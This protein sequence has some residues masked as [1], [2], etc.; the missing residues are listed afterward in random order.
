MSPCLLNSERRASIFTPPISPLCQLQFFVYSHVLNISYCNQLDDKGLEML[1]KAC[2]LM[3]TCNISGCI[4][5][6]DAAVVHLSVHCTHIKTLGVSFCKRFTDR[7]ICTMS[8]Y[9]WLE[10]L[11]VSGCSRKCHRS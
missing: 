9:L 1:A 11:D 6:S 5:L 7:A 3:E 10:E 8:D 2:P 4:L